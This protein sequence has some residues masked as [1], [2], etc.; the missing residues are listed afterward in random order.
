MM[1]TKRDTRQRCNQKAGLRF[2][3]VAVTTVD[4]V[5]WKYRDA[6]VS[7]CY[8][9]QEPSS[10]LYRVTIGDVVNIDISGSFLSAD[11]LETKT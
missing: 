6:L 10:F 5:Y 8:L 9:Y 1:E 2:T 4:R 11:L 3:L 7:H